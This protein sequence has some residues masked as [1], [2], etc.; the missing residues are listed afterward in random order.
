MS[1]WPAGVSRLVSSGSRIDRPIEQDR[2]R[3]YRCAVLAGHGA[4][5][6]VALQV[7]PYRSRWHC[8]RVGRRLTVFRRRF[9]S[10]LLLPTR[11]SGAGAT[12]SSAPVATAALAPFVAF[13]FQIGRAHV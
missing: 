3:P 6:E 8:G 12:T 11:P 7:I 9:A 2:K 4:A 5:L 1:S 10:S 13:E